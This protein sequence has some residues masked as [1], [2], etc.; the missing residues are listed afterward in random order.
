ML[1]D[2]IEG[3]ERAPER[4]LVESKLVVRA[5]SARARKGSRR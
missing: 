5:S 2:R 3:P 4:V 1:F